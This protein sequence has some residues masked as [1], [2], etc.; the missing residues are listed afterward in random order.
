MEGIRKSLWIFKIALDSC[1]RLGAND[2]SSLL[3]H[4]TAVKYVRLL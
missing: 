3:P 1:S 4:H 2:S